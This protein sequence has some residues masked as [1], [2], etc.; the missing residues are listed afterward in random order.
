M[1]MS[2]SAAGPLADGTQLMAPLE[3]PAG[4]TVTMP[5]GA[6]VIAAPGVTITVR[7]VLTIAGANKHAA[8]GTA[9][10]PMGMDGTWGGIVVESGGHLDADGLDLAGA[11]QAV[12]LKAGSLPS[13]YDHGTISESQVPFQIDKSARL[14]TAHAA[15]TNAGA[16]SGISGELHASYLDYETSALSG[17]LITNDNSAVFDVTDSTFHG[18]TVGGG[19]FITSYASTLVHIAYSTI[20]DAHCAL[21]F[22]NVARFEIDHVTAGTKTN[23]PGAWV[24]YGAMLYGGDGPNVISNS[25]FT[26]GGWALD[27]ENAQGPLTITNTYTSGQNS[28]DPTWT[29]APS[30]VAAAPIPDAHP[31]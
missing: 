2:M 23:M 10:P 30:D 11:A 26:G 6:H 28:M 17:G 1:S 25:N 15:V 20:N 18:T 12:W 16:A 4:M 31:R 22:D 29:W 27:Q 9:A 13:R 7:G 24:V 21:H 14:D 8:I 5:A 19:D 3:I